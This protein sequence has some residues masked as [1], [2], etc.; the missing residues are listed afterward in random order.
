ML[1]SF[2]T[3]APAQG[4]TRELRAE[5]QQRIAAQPGAEVGL[6]FEDLAT[7]AT[8]GISDTV[9]FHAASTMKVPV[10]L[11][12]FRR[13]DAGELDL[14]HR[15][16][17]TNRFASIV[18][19]SPYAL[20]RTDDSDDALYQRVGA[21]ISL[22]ELNERMIVRSSNLATNVLIAALDP[23]RVTAFARSLGGEGVVVRRGVEDGLA[24]RA[25]L[26]NVTT[27]RGLGKLLAALEQ[28]RAASA[29][30]T[31]AMRRTLMRQEFNDE[32][33]AGLPAGTPVAHK[34]GWITGTTHDAAIV[35]PPHRAPFVLVI[36]TRGI[37]ER[38]AAQR[39]M[40]D[41]ARIVWDYATRSAMRAPAES[42]LVTP[43]AAR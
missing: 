22:L 35:Y 33:P 10:M 31:I 30:A 15:I 11:E 8:L 3:L 27:A 21:P 9:I 19:G 28:G 14:Q 17:L 36:L 29:W 26:N 1:A 23:T 13:A 4:F 41:L 34:T 43:S 6:W 37:A 24:Y 25:G 7:G 39:L 32:I 20:A 18:D 16:P 38:S 5:L 40:A 12:L 2:S 42:A